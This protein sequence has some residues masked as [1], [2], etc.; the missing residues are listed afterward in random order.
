MNV[1]IQDTTFRDGAQSLWAM[2]I[3]HG[4]M[5]PVATDM[6]NA[7]FAVIEVPANPIHFKKYIR[8]LKENPFDLM[9]MLA[10]KMPKTPKAAMGGGL[11]L[12]PFGTP[13]PP[14]LGKLYQKT[15][16]DIGVLNR[17]QTACNTGDQLTRQLPIWVPFLKGVG[18]KLA[19]AI[20]YSISPRHTDELYAEK[21]RGAAALK[22]DAIYLK[23][24]GGLLTVDRLR[25][26]MPI[27]MKEA[28]DIPV[29]LHSHCTTGLAPLV[30]AEALKLGVKTLHCGIPPLADG[31]AQPSVLDMIKNARLMGYCIDLDEKLL[32]SVSQ[33]LY[34][35][36]RQ[37]NMP[38]GEPMRYD[39]AQYIH[40][41][42]G[43]VISNLRFQ[44]SEIGLAH[45]LDEVIQECIQIRKD[46][47]YPIMITPY[48]QFV[49]TQAAINVATGAR[50]KVV[51]DEL[52]RFAQG[53]FGEDS[54]Y[55]WM[56]Q[57]L[58]DKWLALPRAKELAALG[59]RQIDDI[60][61][62]ECRRKFGPPGISDE[63]L[64]MRAIMGG[65][66]EIET[67]IAAG[68]PKRYLTS[69]LPLVTLL[70][71]LKKHSRVR[72]IHVQ[73]G[74]DSISLHKRGAE[75]INSTEVSS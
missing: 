12:N 60:S 4:M 61:L 75:A 30:Y 47:G 33:R 42:P 64:M 51:I 45:R 48:S 18:Y 26:L 68:P 6:D 27:I 73:R 49:G 74:A 66:E 25:T 57:N 10:R 28:G 46:L 65:A 69:D 11:N 37:D 63:E 53:V 58:K 21:T 52:I 50:Y 35:I 14:A 5:E 59:K 56:D 38:L 44:L 2:A 7:G 34:A 24:Q 54:G 32:Q 3:R 36:A 23:D 8:D 40:Q 20:S 71:E 22:P 41:I 19:L 1:R 9:R 62:A 31:P 39:C 13:T 72:Y 15:L 29:E 70:N 16:F 55:T 43:G 67:M 17:I